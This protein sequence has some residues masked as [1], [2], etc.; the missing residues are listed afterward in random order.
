[1][2][3]WYWKLVLWFI[4]ILSPA[5]ALVLLNRR[6]RNH[7]L[8]PG[9]LA[10]P[11]FG[12]IFSLGTMPHRTLAGMKKKYGPVIWL[13]LASMDTVVILTTDVATEFFKNHDAFF[14]DRTVN[15]A[16][17]SHGY[18]KSSMVVAPYGAY[19]RKLRRICMSEIFTTKRISEGAAIRQKCINDLLMWIEK[20]A[21]HEGPGGPG[22]IQIT[23]LT[24]F[25]LFN[26]M[27]NI[28][29]SRDLVD[30]ESKVGSEFYI[31]V[32]G[33]TQLAATPNI[34]DLFPC[35]KGRDLQGIRRKMDPD[36]GKTLE[37]VSGFIKERMKEREEG[38]EKKMDFLDV[39]LDFQSTADD[40][41]NKLLEQDIC[42]FTTELFMTGAETTAS[43]IE[44][45][46]AELLSNP[47]IMTNVQA[48]L[49]KVVGPNKKLVENDIH[50]L[51]Y[52]EAVVKE[53]LR[54]HPP[55]PFLVPRRAI[56][57]VNFMGYHLPKNTQV[58]VNAW[59]IGRDP[60]YWDEP[61]SFKPD[62][63]LGS[64]IDFRGQNFELI[65]FGSGRR[66]CPAISLAHRVL[67]LILGSLLH[68]FDWQLDGHI[69]PEEM[70]MKESQGITTRKAQPLKAIPKK[71]KHMV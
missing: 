68:E 67:P 4:I 27:G 21:N 53:T 38:G 20:E 13:K 50:K 34:S 63:F 71:S 12:H 25:T 19:W 18:H 30:T 39:L 58:L 70:D 31:A 47:K 56:Q 36:M 54:L 29:L 2:E 9:P 14:V 17:K 32:M 10:W 41:P 62:R 69:I 35:Q 1:M 5:T 60:E 33:M 15:E 57:D 11:V 37:T 28:V 52:M 16:M 3:Y 43:T 55:V 42:V 7:L 44:W 26:I 65:P 48:E 45:A 49:A 66:I 40:E 46:L 6:G 22:I 51:H 24:F 59:A 8:P 64:N 61:L 23:Q